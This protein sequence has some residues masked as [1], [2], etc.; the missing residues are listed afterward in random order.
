MLKNKFTT[1]VLIMVLTYE[2]ENHILNTLNRISLGGPSSVIYKIVIFDDFSKDKTIIQAKKFKKYPIDIYKNEKNVGYGGNQKIGY[3]YAIKN[4]FDYVVMLHGD[5][6]YPAEMIP[7][8]VQCAIRHKA[9]AVFGSRM[10]D[11]KNALAGGMPFYKFIGNILLTNIQNKLLRTNLSEFHSGFRLYK[12][13]SLKS[14]PIKRNSDGFD[15]DT[16]IIIQF[17]YAN[18]KICEIKIP[19]RY[20]DEV[21]RVNGIKYA[22]DIIVTSIQLYLQRIGLRFDERFNVYSGR[23]K[24][25]PKTNYLSS[26]TEAI[27]LI[28]SE[29]GITI[30]DVGAGSNFISDYSNNRKNKIIGLDLQ[31]SDSDILYDKF[32]VHDLNNGLPHIDKNQKIDI[33]LLLDVLEHLKN[34][35]EFLD[36]LYDFCY[37]HNTRSI[38]VSVPNIGFFINRIMLIFGRFEYS[39][40]GIMD[41]T[42]LRF[43]TFKTIERNFLNTRF[44][45]KSKKGLPPPFELIFNN[46]IFIKMSYF[47]FKLAIIILPSLFSYQIFL[48]VKIKPTI[49]TLKIK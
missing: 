38:L 48:Q 45:I 3:K 9:D 36:I 42:H 46:K 24:Y 11:K 25:A 43:F 5:G 47:I 37:K 2:A 34:P 22:A 14:L 35:I 31:K 33:I 15:F 32:F 6:Q 49:K 10:S 4:N 17:A 7:D 41:I 26:H 44:V 8:M 28:S 27:K 19:T 39:E 1:R 29:S 20:G 12:V 23:S 40:K 13:S 30:F 18:K 16:E 21:C